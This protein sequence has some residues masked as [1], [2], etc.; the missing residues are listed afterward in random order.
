MAECSLSDLHSLGPVNP[1]PTYK[2]GADRKIDFMLGSPNISASVCRAGYLAYD[3]GIFSKHRGLYVDLDF[4]GLMGPIASIQP[5]NVRHLRSEDQSAVDRYVEAFQSYASDHNL[6]QRVTDLTAVASSLPLH[7]CKDTYDAL[8]RDITRA[9]L[10]S[11]K[12]AK[13]PTGKYAWLPILREAGLLARYWHL[14]LSEVQKGYCLRTPLLALQTR[15]R[16]LKFTI[17]DDQTSDVEIIKSRWKVALKA[18]RA[19]RAT[20]FDHR[21]VHLKT[22]LIHYENQESSSEIREK[23]QRIK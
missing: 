17:D 7:R 10:H 18:L 12:S 6:W 13:R 11:E 14:R 19:V 15:L 4:H 22:T 1:P 23:I 9:M 5:A 20:A 21:A 3:D 8:D 16:H 2:Y